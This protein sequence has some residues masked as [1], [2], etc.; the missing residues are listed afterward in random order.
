MERFERYIKLVT[1]AG[2][3]IVARR[4]WQTKF[5][6]ISHS[7]SEVSRARGSDPHASFERSTSEVYIRI[8]YLSYDKA[9]GVDRTAS[10]AF[11][12]HQSSSLL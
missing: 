3:V 6:F 12:A 1:S 5:K 2:P 4:P 10:S 8:N 7:D 11:V 9:V